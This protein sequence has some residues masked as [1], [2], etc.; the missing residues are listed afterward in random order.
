MFGDVFESAAIED[1]LNI[2]LGRIVGMFPSRPGKPNL[3]IVINGQASTSNAELDDEQNEK[4][5]HIEEKQNL[6][7]LDGAN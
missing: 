2:L 3:G 5:H 6:V 7:V 4:D 1:S